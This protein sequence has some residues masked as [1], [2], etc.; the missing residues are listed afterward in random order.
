LG[1]PEISP[2]VETPTEDL[3]W[4]GLVK[5]QEWRTSQYRILVEELEWHRAVDAENTFPFDK[6]ASRVIFAETIELRH[7]ESNTSLEDAKAHLERSGELVNLSKKLINLGEAAEAVVAA[8]KA[9]DVL[10]GFE[11][12]TAIEGVYWREFGR[13]WQELTYRLWAAGRYD[14]MV[15]PAMEA[16]QVYRRALEVG[17]AN[18]AEIAWEILA[19]SGYL[20]NA[21]KMTEAVIA[22]WV[23]V[24]VTLAFVSLYDV[25]TEGGY[26]YLFGRALDALALWLIA[27]GQFDAA[28]GPAM[29]AVQVYRR[30]AAESG[31]EFT[32]MK[33]VPQLKGLSE[34][35]TAAGKT[36]EAA[37]A[38]QA[39]DDVLRQS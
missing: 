6:L 39:A 5:L 26:S 2:L 3:L 35:L 28:V 13:A 7:P 19:I 30:A 15:S 23:T 16:V 21:G 8:Q 18:G 36:E 11:P 9:V 38:E 29:E 24:D 32:T 4:Q 20:A 37:A 10:R 25:D 31:V 22:A 12:P 14:E 1:D 34:R 33:I 27:V 17:Y